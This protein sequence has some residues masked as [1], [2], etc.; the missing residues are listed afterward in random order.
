VQ[1]FLAIHVPVAMVIAIRL[2]SDIGFEA[3]TYVVLVSA[4]A[5]GQQTGGLVLKRLKRTS[6]QVTSC[7][8]VDLYR[9]I[10]N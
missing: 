10:R 5:L 8:V 1:W 4:F 3:Y 9:F 2:L 7:M 6:E